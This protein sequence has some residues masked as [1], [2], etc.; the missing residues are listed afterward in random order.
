MQPLP[1]KK[2]SPR[3]RI[4]EVIIEVILF[5]VIMLAWDALPY[6]L[7][8]VAIIILLILV[9]RGVLRTWKQ[10]FGKTQ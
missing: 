10:M 4:V 1:M 5:L 9:T 3:R 8:L 6:P 2:L 7:L